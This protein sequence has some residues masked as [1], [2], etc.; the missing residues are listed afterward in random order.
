MIHAGPT[1][2]EELVENVKTAPRHWLL[3]ICC[4]LKSSEDMGHVWPP[5]ESATLT[6][7]EQ[8]VWKPHGSMRD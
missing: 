2:L 6:V 8:A 1:M 5:K 3:E 7:V 4:S